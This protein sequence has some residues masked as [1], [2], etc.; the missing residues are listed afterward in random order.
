MNLESRSQFILGD[1]TWIPILS[2]PFPF[3]GVIY[4]EGVYF[5]SF[6]WIFGT[7]HLFRE[8]GLDKHG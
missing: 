4:Y 1:F 7:W 6:S 3:V 2:L 8:T 5:S